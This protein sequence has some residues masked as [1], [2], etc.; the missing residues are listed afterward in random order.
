[1]FWAARLTSSSR[2][3][4]ESGSSS[5]SSL[6]SCFSVMSAFLSTL[7]SGSATVS[8]S[9][10][11]KSSAASSSSESRSTSPLSAFTLFPW[12]KSIPME[13]LFS[14]E[15]VISSCSAS[16]TETSEPGPSSSFLTRKINSSLAPSISL[17]TL[18]IKFL[19]QDPAV[20][21]SYTPEPFYPALQY[22]QFEELLQACPTFPELP[23]ESKF[24]SRFLPPVS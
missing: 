1:M 7:S 2:L 6:L 14:G 12:G 20:C 4:S 24:P 15:V 5:A 11:S 17:L 19:P 8:S 10:I 22:S 13:Y 21:L 18:I 3:S 23:E 16:G 9:L